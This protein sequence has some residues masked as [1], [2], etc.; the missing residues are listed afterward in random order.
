MF[1]FFFLSRQQNV[2]PT[3]GGTISPSKKKLQFLKCL[4]MIGYISTP[5]EFQKCPLIK[6]FLFIARAPR[7]FLSPSPLSDVYRSLCGITATR[8]AVLSATSHP[9]AM[10]KDTAINKN[11]AFKRDFLFWQRRTATIVSRCVFLPAKGREIFL[12]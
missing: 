3:S 4:L 9:S 6:F 11:E 2:F 7:A 5:C 8:Q 12:L 1:V 10:V